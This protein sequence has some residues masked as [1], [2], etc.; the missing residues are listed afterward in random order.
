MLLN[1]Y[2]VPTR[3]KGCSGLQAEFV[4]GLVIQEVTGVLACMSNAKATSHP[5]LLSI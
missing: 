1:T 2:Y 4:A 5:W 3:G